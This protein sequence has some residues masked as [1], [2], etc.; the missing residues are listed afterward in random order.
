MGPDSPAWS[1]RSRLLRDSRSSGFEERISETAIAAPKRRARRRK[2]RS[3]MPAIGA[4]NNPLGRICAPILIAAACR[5]TNENEGSGFYPLLRR[6]RIT[7]KPFCFSRQ[8]GRPVDHAARK[9]TPRRG[10]NIQRREQRG[11]RRAA[12]APRAEAR[13]GEEVGHA[14][15]RLRVQAPACRIARQSRGIAGIARLAQDLRQVPRI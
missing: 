7:S 6:K 11:A 1:R 4:T 8:R 10:K 9:K 3:V 12:E 15:R 13:A 2:G 14:D 5:C